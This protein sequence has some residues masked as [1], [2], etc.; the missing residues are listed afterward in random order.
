MKLP[1]FIHSYAGIKFLLFCSLGF[2]LMRPSTNRKMASAHRGSVGHLPLLKFG[3]ELWPIS[4]FDNVCHFSYSPPRRTLCGLQESFLILTGVH[5]CYV[6]DTSHVPPL[7]QNGHISKLNSQQHNG[8]PS[9]DGVRPSTVSGGGG[10]NTPTA[11]DGSLA[12]RLHASKAVGL[13]AELRVTLAKLEDR[14]AFLQQLPAET[15]KFL[16]QWFSETEKEGIS[17]R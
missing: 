3:S 16:Q 5:P 9:L 7:P 14:A 8:R 12:R 1:L 10:A 6:T 15:R 13:C 17:V 4:G 2:A 11:A